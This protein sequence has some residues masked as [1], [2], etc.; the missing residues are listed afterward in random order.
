MT[1]R[2]SSRPPEQPRCRDCGGTAWL[3][4][5]VP[6]YHYPSGE[7]VQHAWLC[8]P[9]TENRVLT[10]PTRNKYPGV[11]FETDADRA[12]LPRRRGAA[13][14]REKCPNFAELHQAAW[15]ALTHRLQR[16][17]SDTEMV[18]ALA[19]VMNWTGEPDDHRKTLNDYR[20]DFGIM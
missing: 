1:D 10:S 6:L 14:R 2:P 7:L 4:A 19:F 17:P 8:G 12:P 18:R 16:A 15:D 20:K 5:P 11:L 13:S 3:D 9:C